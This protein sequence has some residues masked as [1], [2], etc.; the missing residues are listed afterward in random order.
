MLRAGRDQ[1]SERETERA[2]ENST[3]DRH[4]ARTMCPGCP[5]GVTFAKEQ[6]TTVDRREKRG[7]ESRQRGEGKREG[8]RRREGG[9]D[10]LLAI[11]VMVIMSYKR[12][13]D[14]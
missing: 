4:V 14:L 7:R 12:Y 9:S 13:F 1:E 11:F 8:E 2:R 3:R 6:S 5:V 10:L